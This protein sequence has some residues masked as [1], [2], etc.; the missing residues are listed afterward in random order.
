MCFGFWRTGGGRSLASGQP[1]LGEVVVKTM[2][3]HTVTYFLIG[4][5]A[6]WSFG[7]AHK[8]AEPDIRSLMRQ[9]DEP[10]VMAGPLF[11]PIRGLLFGF[12][13]YLLRE[14]LFGARAGWLV[15]WL[16]LVIIGILGTFGPAPGSLEGMVY[17]TLPFHFHLESLPEIIV[18]AL[19]LAA[20]LGYWVNA[21]AKWWLTWGLGVAF[22]VVLLLPTLGLLAGRATAP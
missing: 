22:V 19:A 5:A 18:Q 8:F 7:Y 2:V 4:L 11:Q 12:V 1:S 17:T 6:F 3:T 14:P 20:L 16:V 10:L 9:T 15:L 13:F 21:P